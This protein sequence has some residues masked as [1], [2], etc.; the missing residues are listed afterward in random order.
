MLDLQTQVEAVSMLLGVLL[1]ACYR[2]RN[3]FSVCMLS[4]R[5][6]HDL[7]SSRSV[8][9]VQSVQC[10]SSASSAPLACIAVK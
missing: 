6:G 7:S 9:D 10:S 1:V 2:T 8:L 3:F 5:S 4:D